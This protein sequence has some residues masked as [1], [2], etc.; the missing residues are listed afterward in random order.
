VK[1]NV[2]LGWL[3]AAYAPES[4]HATEPKRNNEIHILLELMKLTNH[5]W[6]F[7]KMTTFL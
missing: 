4:W 7:V 2:L 1:N 5:F 3:L 6:T